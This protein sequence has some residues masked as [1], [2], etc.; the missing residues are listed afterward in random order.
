MIHIWGMELADI[1]D[2]VGIRIAEEFLV[3]IVMIFW[4]EMQRTST[5]SHL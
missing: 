2:L 4:F 3:L 1:W 5:S